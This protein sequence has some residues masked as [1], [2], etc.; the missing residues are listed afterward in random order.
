MRRLLVVALVATALVAVSAGSAMA[1]NAGFRSAGLNGENRISPFGNGAAY[2][3][4]QDLGVWLFV[5]GDSREALRASMDTVEVEFLLDGEAVDITRAAV[6]VAAQSDIAQHPTD[7]WRSAIGDPSVGPLALG[8]HTL[9]TTVSG[10]TFSIW[11][12]IEDC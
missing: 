1:D 4:S 9:D 11:F 10:F 12:T 3:A 7:A 6:S 8:S 5:I 2:C